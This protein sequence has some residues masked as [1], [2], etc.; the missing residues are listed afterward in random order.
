[1]KLPL[2]GVGLLIAVGTAL[3]WHSEVVHTFGNNT[4][5]GGYRCLMLVGTGNCHQLWLSGLHQTNVT[6]S[7]IFYGGL[8]MAIFGGLMPKQRKDGDL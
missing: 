3:W 2:M 5:A 6:A 4:P 1:M 7:V 8:L